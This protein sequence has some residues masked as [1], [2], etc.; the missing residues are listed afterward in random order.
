[1]NFDDSGF[2]AFIPTGDLEAGQYRIGI[3]IKKGEI[4]ALKYTDE[5]ITVDLFR[6][7]TY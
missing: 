4:E 5:I 3:Y 1:M 6:D 7:S 2:L